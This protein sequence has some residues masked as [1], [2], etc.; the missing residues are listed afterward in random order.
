M[1][2]LFDAFQ[3]IINHPIASAIII[4]NLVLM[5]SILSVDNAAVLATM[6]M[7]MKKKDRQK[8]LRYGILGAYF[9]RGVCLIFSALLIKIF[10]LKPLGG[11]YLL[12]LGGGYFLSRSKFENS[13]SE[14]KKTWFYR[15]TLGIFGSFWATVISIELMDLA[16]SI[17]NVFAAVA[18][19]DN[20]LLICSGVFIGILAM[21]FVSQ[22]FVKLMDK[23]P[24]LQTSA[25]SI[26][27]LLGVRLLFSLYEKSFPT[28]TLTRFMN[29]H[30][31]ETFFSLITIGIF[32]LPILISKIFKSS[33]KK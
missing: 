31:A 5:E 16:F 19:S 29:S 24:F 15:N 4:G 2:E 30:M 18:F 8:A 6:V 21:R 27:L 32:F 25:F 11:L 20:L 3:D 1:S 17:D 13:T 9:F 12:Y 33:E 22:T 28:A 23:Y 26:I 10:W 14:K 7:G